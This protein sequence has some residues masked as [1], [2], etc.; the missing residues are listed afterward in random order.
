[1]LRA[2]TWEA[3]ERFAA[4]LQHFPAP[5]PGGLMASWWNEFQTQ[6]W[7]P[8]AARSTNSKRLLPTGFLCV[9]CCGYLALTSP[10]L[11]R[12]WLYSGANRGSKAGQLNS[13][14]KGNH[15]FGFVTVCSS[16]LSLFSVV[17]LIAPGTHAHINREIAAL[18]YYWLL[19]AMQQ[20]LMTIL[21]SHGGR[22][23]RHMIFTIA[24]AKK[25]GRLMGTVMRVFCC[26]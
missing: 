25:L 23:C 24:G 11:G 10:H 9:S 16:H 26:V 4:L 12:T 18:F 15:V 21:A 3:N 14:Q 13:W 2:C 8:L 17:F 7:T 6:R 20:H 1:M 5:V 19:A 22:I